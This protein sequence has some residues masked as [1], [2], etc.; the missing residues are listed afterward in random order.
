[1]CW[2]TGEHYQIWI[3]DYHHIIYIYIYI[4]HELGPPFLS[5]QYFTECF[6]L[7]WLNPSNN[8]SW[9]LS[10]HW[11]CWPYQTQ[12]LKG[13]ISSVR[14][15]EGLHPSLCAVGLSLRSQLFLQCRGSADPH[16]AQALP[17]S[18]A[19]PLEGGR[20]VTFHDSKTFQVGES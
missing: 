20:S 13:R 14:N 11:L 8:V 18:G 12:T 17:M 9:T 7:G 5:N 4:I 2:M 15:D 19:W 6:Y 3:T 1:M 10:S 16:A